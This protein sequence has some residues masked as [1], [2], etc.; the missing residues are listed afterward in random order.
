[1]RLILLILILFLSF[2]S[3]S[4]ANDVSEF[5][6]EGMSVGDSLLDFFSLKKI[7]DEIKNAMFYPNSK[8]FMIISLVPNNIKQ[9]ENINFHIKANDEKYL[10]YSIKGLSYMET[11]DCL[12]LKK[13]VVKEI[14][15][16]IPNA[17]LSKHTN[18]YNKT[19]G[20]SKAFINDYYIS[21]GVIRVFCTDWD[22]E[23][24]EK[25][26]NL[27]YD[28]TLSVVASNNEIVNWIKNE[29]YPK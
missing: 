4:R 23:F 7:K 29:A 1:M 17:E 15:S 26:E 13:D 24:L 5:E 16:I 14:E 12:N 22:N 11:N 27:L 10:I 3:L 19:M 2:Q 20:K 6:I 9:Y 18:D 21:N 25:E 28:D 8:K